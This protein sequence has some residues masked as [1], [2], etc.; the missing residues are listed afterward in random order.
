MILVPWMSER[1]ETSFLSSASTSIRQAGDDL[2][3]SSV[4]RGEENSASFISAWKVLVAD[5]VKEKKTKNILLFL[6]R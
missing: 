5:Q 2:L 1:E 4:N 3:K 6:Y